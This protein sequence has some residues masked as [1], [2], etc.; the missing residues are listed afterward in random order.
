MQSLRG[1]G[2]WLIGVA[3]LCLAG[4]C[5]AQDAEA[6]ADPDAP[7]PAVEEAAAPEELGFFGGWEGNVAL[8]LNGSSGNTDNLNLRA[9][10]DA[11]R[12]TEQIETTVLALFEYA[13]EDSEDT[14][15]RFLIGA[16]NDWLFPD[17]PWRFFVEGSYELD[18]FQDWDSR[19]SGFAGFGYEFIN[20]DKTLLIGRVGAG[21]SQDY[22]GEDEDFRP[23][24]LLGL[25]FSHQIS[26]RQKITA[27]TRL[28]PDLDDTG[29][30]RWNTMAKWQITVDPD[31]N[32]NLN[33][34]VENR[35]DS[36]PGGDDEKNDFSYFVTL[37]WSF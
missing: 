26:E 5:L 3:T 15:N 12:T 33:V 13:Q 19:L 4:T 22:G 1:H 31:L 29:E 35:Y 25:E 11:K 20:D 8:G 23:E 7:D 28:F 17:S 30:Y 21:G 10:F 9:S 14:E 34:G 24:G 16:R 32:M 36:Q 37:G 27:L 2:G 18:E 6:P